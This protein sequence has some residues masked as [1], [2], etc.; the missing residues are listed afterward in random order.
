MTHK[1]QPHL[2]KKELD[3][4]EQTGEEF[5]LWDVAFR[6]NSTPQV[7][8]FAVRQRGAVC[9]F[10]P[11]GGNGCGKDHVRYKFVKPNEVTDEKSD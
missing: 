9:T 1:P 11:K 10:R 7:L 6:L 4:L 2:I 3:R 8:S 5:R